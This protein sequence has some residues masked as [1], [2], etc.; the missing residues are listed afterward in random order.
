MVV[1]IYV[2]EIVF[3]SMYQHLVEQFVKHMS[4]EYEMSLVEE[5]TYWV[6]KYGK[7]T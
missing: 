5:L 4:T 6:F 7:I 2:D 1:Q 3:G